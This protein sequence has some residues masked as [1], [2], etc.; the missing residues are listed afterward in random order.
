[1][2]L[3]AIGIAGQQIGDKGSDARMKRGEQLIQD[4]TRGC[5]GRHRVSLF[6]F[7]VPLQNHASRSCSRTRQ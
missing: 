4:A 7:L 5:R 6:L 2:E 1:M 3:L